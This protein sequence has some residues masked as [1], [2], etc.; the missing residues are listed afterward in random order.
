MTILRQATAYLGGK[1]IETP[2]LDAEVLMAH[3]LG[4]PRIQLYVQFERPL[5][6]A[7]LDAY[8]EKIARRAARW[9][10]AYLVGQ[11][12]FYGRDFGVDPRVLVPRPETEGLVEAALDRLRGR[13]EVQVADLGTGSGVIGI[14]LACE[15]PA[16]RVWG[17]DLSRDALAVA[18]A[19]AERHGVADRFRALY[20]DW[21]AALPDDLRGGFSAI[22]SNPPYLAAGEVAQAAP[23]LRREPRL[24]LTDEADGLSFYRRLAREA[25]GW[26]APG[27]FVAVELGADQN[28]P[29]RALFVAG[30]W[31]IVE[32]RDDLAGCPRVLVAALGPGAGG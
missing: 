2:R 9:P 1:G 5:V 25:A 18:V 23:E 21:L 8:R 11:K 15:L 12:E 30:G 28:E 7:E 29:V 13:D 14:S 3:V 4:V 22:V 16:A 10:V 27:G 17:V 32:V 24:A 19:N 6:A 20:G 26:L 31:T